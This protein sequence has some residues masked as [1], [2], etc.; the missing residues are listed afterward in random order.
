VLRT[1]ARKFRKGV[2]HRIVRK[3]GTRAMRKRIWDEEFRRGSWEYIDHTE[4]DAI[5]PC[6][7]RY[8]RGGDIL[9]LGCGA[10]NTGN[11][12]EASAYRR[13]VGVDISREA[14]QRAVARSKA[15]GRG[16]ANVYETGDILGY[17]PAS[18]Y[19]VILFRESIFYLPLARIRE[20]LDRL[21][22]FLTRD[23]VFVVRMCDRRRHSRIVRTIRTGYPVLE[24]ILPEER[25][26]I[27][28][29]APAR[30]P[31]GA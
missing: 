1:L 23:G 10:G 26:I 31:S 2:L 14:V 11:E 3:F 27:L 7:Q 30:R 13:Y 28:V 19:S 5:Y 16:E 8:C 18:R 17:V 15:C 21:S 22:S 25:S 29:F 4:G 6:L 24:E 12:L 9:D 20:T